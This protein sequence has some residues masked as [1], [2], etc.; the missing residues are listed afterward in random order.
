MAGCAGLVSKAPVFRR[1]PCVRGPE[2][3]TRPSRPEH[4]PKH[5]R[6]MRSLPTAVRRKG[7]T[8]WAH[9]SR[10]DAN[11]GVHRCG[12]GSAWLVALSW[13]WSRPVWCRLRGP[14]SVSA[15]APY[16]FVGMSAEN[17]SWDAGAEQDRQL[18]SMASHGV[19]E[20][21]QII[22]WSYIQPVQ[23]QLLLGLD[24]QHHPERR[25]RGHPRAAD[26]RRRSPVGNLEAGRRPA[27]LPVPAEQQPD[28]RR[29]HP[30]RRAAL[31]PR[32]RAVADPPRSR[33]ASPS[34]AGRFGTRPT[35]T[36][37]GPARASRRRTPSPPG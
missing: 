17:V 24:R 16:G 13:A 27:R 6:C 2:R 34:P 4:S 29:V 9:E 28:L 23:D 10:S 32:R 20:L 37:S 11:I 3:E 1:C 35:P 31:R 5:L 18:A 7:Q 26:R 14:G 15:E 19:T 22:R 21:R 8:A 36:R 30:P 33:T 12:R 25:A